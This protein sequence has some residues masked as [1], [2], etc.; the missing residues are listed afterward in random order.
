MRSIHKVAAAS[1]LAIGLL[2][3]AAGIASATEPN[4]GTTTSTA[5]KAKHH[6]KVVLQGTVTAVAPTSITIT[7]HGGRW[8]AL[9]GTSVVFVVTTTT[10]VTRNDADSTIASVKVGDHANIKGTK[11]DAVYTAVRISASGL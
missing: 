11:V 8:K 7:V 5:A 1:A 4:H 2:V 9:R 3:P 10:K 6:H